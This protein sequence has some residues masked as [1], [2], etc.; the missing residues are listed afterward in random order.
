MRNGPRGSY[1]KTGTD[2][3]YVREM[4]AALEVDPPVIVWEKDSRGILVAVEINDPHTVK[5][6]R[7]RAKTNT[8]SLNSA[9][10]AI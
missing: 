2:N 6:K 8:P 10:R 4:D 9:R 7:G 5:R 3:A 1:D